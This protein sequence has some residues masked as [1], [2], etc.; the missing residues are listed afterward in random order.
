MLILSKY[1]ETSPIDR[2]LLILARLSLRPVMRER[3]YIEREGERGSERERE[4]E[5]ERDTEREREME[6]YM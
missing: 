4:G 5:G 1:N 3:K 6:I 2:D